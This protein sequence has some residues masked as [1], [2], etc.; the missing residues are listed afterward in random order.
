[1]HCGKTLPY[2]EAKTVESKIADA[3]S[4]SSKKKGF[5]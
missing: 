1:M 5:L 4:Y 2:L 3:K